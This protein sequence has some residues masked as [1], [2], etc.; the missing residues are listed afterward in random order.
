[1]NKA[2]EIKHQFNNSYVAKTTRKVFLGKGDYLSVAKGR[3]RRHMPEK[4]LSVIHE[5]C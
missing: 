5:K 4:L 3:K 1:M 2:A